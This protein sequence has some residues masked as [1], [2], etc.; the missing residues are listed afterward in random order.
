MVFLSNRIEHIP[1]RPVDRGSRTKIAS[2]DAWEAE[3]KPSERKWNA[4]EAAAS[5]LEASPL[6]L[7]KVLPFSSASAA[8]LVGAKT[9][10]SKARLRGEGAAIQGREDS[11]FGPLSGLQRLRCSAG[12]PSGLRAV[13]PLLSARAVEVGRPR[14]ASRRPRRA[15]AAMLR[16][17][18]AGETEAGEDEGHAQRRSGSRAGRPVRGPV[19]GNLGKGF[20]LRR[21]CLCVF[22]LR[23]AV[24][25]LRVRPDRVAELPLGLDGAGGGGDRDSGLT[26]VGPRLPVVGGTM[27]CGGLRPSPRPSHAERQ[28]AGV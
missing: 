21:R 28:W 19:R 14:P 16:S 20:V 26:L 5:C 8:A 24:M 13:R 17:G 12:P 27:G 11:G 1:P 18:V 9:T 7:P 23:P 4:V 3:P 15:A 6:R 22:A 2:R 25:G 10:P